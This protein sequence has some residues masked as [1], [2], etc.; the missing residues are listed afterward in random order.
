MCTFAHPPDAKR[1]PGSPQGHPISSASQSRNLPP[2]AACNQEE[3]P[4]EIVDRLDQAR[5]ACN[6]LEHPFYQRW[7]AGELT[8]GELAL[9]AGEYRHAV[10][11]LA[12]A[13]QLAAD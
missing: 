7:T 5:S 2:R 10:V 8:A 4:V 6:V 13:S 1:A 11:A 12:R 3:V 9:Y